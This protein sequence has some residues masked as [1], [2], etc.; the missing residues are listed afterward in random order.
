MSQQNFQLN[1]ISLNEESWARKHVYNDDIDEQQVDNIRKF[2]I[3]KRE[4]EMETKKS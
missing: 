3:K 1:L 4:F 2:I